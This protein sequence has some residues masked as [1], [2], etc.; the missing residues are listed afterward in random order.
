MATAA[1]TSRAQWDQIVTI[2]KTEMASG[3]LKNCN[4][5][6]VTG[7]AKTTTLQDVQRSLHLYTD[8]LPACGVQ[9]KSYSLTPEGAGRR[10]LTTEFV[11]LLTANATDYTDG[12]GNTVIANA[13]D[14]MAHGYAL[15]SDGSGNGICEIFRDQANYTLGGNAGRGSHITNI[16]AYAQIAPAEGG[17]SQVWA[18]YYITLVAES[19][20][21]LF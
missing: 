13:A 8:K 17:N 15:V 12:S 20:V 14:A 2:L 10:K 5:T 4:W 1:D 18:D 7:A 16:Q 21:N 19:L 6:D 9:L 3:R 11:I